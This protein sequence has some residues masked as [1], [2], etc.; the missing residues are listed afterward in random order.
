MLNRPNTEVPN[1]GSVKSDGTSN[2][3]ATHF[4]NISLRI[5]VNRFAKEF[6][7]LYQNIK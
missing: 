6:K 3:D 1:A 2:Y 5:L 7:K 4:D